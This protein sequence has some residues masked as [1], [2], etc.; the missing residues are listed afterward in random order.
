MSTSQTAERGPEEGS[1]EGV[2]ITALLDDLYGL[3][4]RLTGGDEARAEELVRRTLIASHRGA[5]GHEPATDRRAWLTDLLRETFAEA[6]RGRTGRPDAAD[7]A[8]DEAGRSAPGADPG[9]VHLERIADE[10]VTRAIEELPEELR[11]PLVLSDLDCLRY[12]EIAELLAI[13][14]GVVEARLHRARR[15][16]GRRLRDHVDPAESGGEAEG[17]PTGEAAEEAAREPAGGMDC[18]DA[19]ARVHE[20][21]DGELDADVQERLHGHVEVCARC[22][23]TFDRARLF[24]D[25][26]RR[27]GFRTRTDDGVRRRIAAL[28]E[29]LR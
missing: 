6:Y 8:E 3:A 26:L 28:E 16:L 29:E 20:Y 14:R 13:P 7:H 25:H 10:T 21:L 15:R 24:L 23:P 27:V 4:L 19:L 5:V 22:Y 1:E 11:V 17:G 2:G 18:E 12:A 9:S